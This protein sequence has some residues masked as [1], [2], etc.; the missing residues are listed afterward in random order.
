VEGSCES[1]NEPS[2]FIKCL[3]IVE[4]LSDWLIINKGSVPWSYLVYFFLSFQFDVLERVRG[5]VPPAALHLYTIP[6]EDRLVQ[7]RC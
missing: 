2:D 1:G 5:D 7:G 4:W 6:A 3:D